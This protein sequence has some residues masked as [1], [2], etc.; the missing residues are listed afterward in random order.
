MSTKL[1]VCM[2]AAFLAFDAPA[3][4]AQ[5]QRDWPTLGNSSNW[6]SRGGSTLARKNS[7][8]GR[9]DWE[10]QRSDGDIMGF[11]VTTYDFNTTTQDFMKLVLHHETAK[12]S[13]RP[14]PTPVVMTA[15]VPVIRGTTAL[16]LAA[17]AP[18][19]PLAND[20]WV[21]PQFQQGGAS[22]DGGY[23]YILRGDST[24]ASGNIDLAGA[25]IM[26]TGNPNVD[27][28]YAFWQDT[29]SGPGTPSLSSVCRTVYAELLLSVPNGLIPPAGNGAVKHGTRGQSA[30]RSTGNAGH[31]PDTNGNNAGRADDVGYVAR[32]TAGI[33]RPYIFFLSPSLLP[34]PLRDTG[35]AV[36]NSRFFLNL[37]AMLNLGVVVGDTNGEAR[38]LLP[39]AAAKVLPQGAIIYWQTLMVGPGLELVA[40]SLVRQRF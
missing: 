6:V 1:L 9:R 38:L 21:G 18:R 36:H 39:N 5:L 19:P 14:A 4:T 22:S 11:R 10:L 32:G 34:G 7:Y 30:T 25:G 13:H 37:A 31:Y 17:K 2:A 23:V 29:A 26:P 35:I 27:R 24:T 20:L 12:D 15:N 3:Q 28:R 16:A 40:T 33:G 8:I